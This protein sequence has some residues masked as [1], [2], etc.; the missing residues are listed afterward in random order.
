MA[1]LPGSVFGRPVEE[2]SARI[3]FVDFDGARALAAAEQLLR[4][5][6]PNEA[7]LKEYCS[8]TVTAIDRLCEW[9]NG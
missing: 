6:T 4:R 5:R 2:F 1:V 3:S 9:L 8:N 7:L